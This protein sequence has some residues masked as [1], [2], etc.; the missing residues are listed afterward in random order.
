MLGQGDR[1]EPRHQQ[2]HRRQVRGQ[3][4]LLPG[5]ARREGGPQAL[6][7]PVRRDREV[8]ARG[9]RGR[10]PQAAPHGEEGLRRA[11]RRG[12]LRGV[13]LDGRALREGVEGGAARA[14]RRLPRARVA[15]GQR[16]G[17][18][19]RVLRRH[20]RRA[21]AAA[22]PGRLLPALQRA[23]RGAHQGAEVRERLLGPR[24]GLPRDRP[25]P[26]RARARQRHRV[27][28]QGR[29]R[30]P[31]ERAVLRAAGALRLLRLLPRPP[32]GPREGVGART[33]SGSSAGT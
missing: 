14:R 4:R 22:R 18:P 8:L 32:L 1:K 16:P 20:R 26:A 15:G 2:E 29:G 10:A 19:R 25:R 31:R 3:G 12:G 33:P 21:G 17:G 7:R 9:G 28:A 27:R 23:P 6:H 30:G 11:R 13:A 24:G 5:A